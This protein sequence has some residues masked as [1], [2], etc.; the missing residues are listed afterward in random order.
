M[1]LKNY[2]LNQIVNIFI[3]NCWAYILDIIFVGL[4][5]GFF[6]GHNYGLLQIIK[7]NIIK[8]H[9]KMQEK[10]NACL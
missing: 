8:K 7:K 1:V 9:V 5:V 3:F 2:V 4:N 6:L 10:K